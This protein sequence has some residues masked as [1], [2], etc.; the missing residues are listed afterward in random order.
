MTTYIADPGE[1][2]WWRVYGYHTVHVLTT[3]SEVE[4]DAY[5]LNL[6]RG[7]FEVRYEQIRDLHPK[8]PTQIQETNAPAPTQPDGPVGNPTACP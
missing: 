7:G 2:A 5:I 3:A 8:Q 1:P 6:R 4:R